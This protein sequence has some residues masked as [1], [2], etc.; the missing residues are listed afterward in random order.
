[1]GY[2]VVRGR[3]DQAGRSV[4]AEGVPGLTWADSTAIR[5]VTYV[6]ALAAVDAA[7]NVSP[8]TA[9]VT[10][11]VPIERP[12]GSGLLVSRVDILAADPPDLLRG[13]VCIRWKVEVGPAARGFLVFRASKDAASAPVQLTSGPLQGEG[14]V[15]FYDA[16]LP[17]PGDYLY[18]VVV[19]GSAVESGPAPVAW[20]EP[21]PVRIGAPDETLI[22]VYPNPSPGRLR[23]VYARNA[24]GPTTL[25]V[26]DINGRCVGRLTR[27]ADP[28]GRIEWIIEDL[29]G[30]LGTECT[31]GLY[32]ARLCL[33]ERVLPARFLLRRGHQGGER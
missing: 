29:P 24:A 13:S 23:I 5:G 19:V 15:V 21:I 4:I 26:F 11:P 6:Y 31:S 18:W 12:D 1:M 7:G 30:A 14:L 9:E 22:G 33:G 20:L 32:Y 28:A 27:E 17:P 16:P 8:S 10:F 25:E 3:E 2:N